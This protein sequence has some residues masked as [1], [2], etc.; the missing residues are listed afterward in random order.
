M[1]V[2]EQQANLRSL[3]EKESNLDPV[4]STYIIDTIGCTSIADF[5]NFFRAE[6]YEAKVEEVILDK[7]AKKENPLQLSRLRTAWRLASA[8]F[9][10]ATTRVSKAQPGDEEDLDKPL[11]QDVYDNQIKAAK[12]ANV[13]TFPAVLTPCDALFAR[14]F[15]EFRRRVISVYP[16]ARVK[17]LAYQGT[18]ISK[19]R[20]TQIVPG[21]TMKVCPEAELPGQTF[22]SVLEVLAALQIHRH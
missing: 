1:A 13:P 6:E 4:V 3:L 21:V 2:T 22:Q 15:R 16:L 17:S 5:N 14:C 11:A 8:Q 12:T 9:Q 18:V 19:S 10:A 20:K 7:T